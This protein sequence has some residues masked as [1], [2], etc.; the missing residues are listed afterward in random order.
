[1]TLTFIVIFYKISNNDTNNNVIVAFTINICIENLIN[2][3]YLYDR[4]YYDYLFFILPTV[5]IE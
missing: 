5:C 2:N 4:K 3:T 1:M